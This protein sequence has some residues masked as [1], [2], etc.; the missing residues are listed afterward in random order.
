MLK[1][2]LFLDGA[3]ARERIE[4]ARERALRSLLT[5]KRNSLGVGLIADFLKKE[6][7]R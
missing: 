3:D 6:E 5:V 1:Q 2:A 7:E 4:G